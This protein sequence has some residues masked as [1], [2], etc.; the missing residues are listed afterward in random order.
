MTNTQETI[1]DA[2][3]TATARASQMPDAERST[4][5]ASA[6]DDAD[7]VQDGNDSGSTDEQPR[8]N[9]EARYRVERNEA[10]AALEAA[11]AVIESY[12]RAEVERLAADLAAPDDLMTV[13]GVSL[14]DLLTEGGQ[15][16][17]AAVAAS[18]AALLEQRPGLARNP[19][20]PATDPTQGT[21]SERGHHAPSFA[22]LFR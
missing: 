15:V 21:G 4:P 1:T 18:V 10:R 9:R 12:Q 7:A 19:R 5:G 17:S 11:H 16:D 8:A 2:P 20:V 14:A 13:G 22:D 6:A 3:D